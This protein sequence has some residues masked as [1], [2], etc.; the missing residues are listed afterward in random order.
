MWMITSASKFS[1]NA[2]MTYGRRSASWTRG[3]TGAENHITDTEPLGF[4]VVKEMRF[5]FGTE[6][7]W[8]SGAG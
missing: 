4:R 2:K 1:E 7:W 8:V 6:R 3:N 5:I